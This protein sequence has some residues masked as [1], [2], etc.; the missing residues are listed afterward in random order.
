MAVTKQELLEHR[1]NFKPSDQFVR[2]GKRNPI[3]EQLEAS[4]K[5]MVKMLNDAIARTAETEKAAKKACRKFFEE[6]M[7]SE[8]AAAAANDQIIVCKEAS[9]D[10]IAQSDDLVL[11]QVKPDEALEMVTAEAEEDMEA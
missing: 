3:I 1:K 2:L 11:D 5:A 10:G 7:I 4:N 8:A 6:K 9:E